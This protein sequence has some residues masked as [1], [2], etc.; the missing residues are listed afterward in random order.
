M[1]TRT[2]I[3]LV[4]AAACLQGCATQRKLSAIR[5]ESMSARLSL[6]PKSE[7][8]RSV[9][10]SGLNEKRDTIRIVD[11]DGKEM[12]LMNAIQDD[13]GD[14]VAME[15]LDAVV[16]TAT[17]RNVA[18]R[19]GKVDLQ[20]QI[21]VPEAMQDSRWQLRFYPDMYIMQDSVRLESIIITGNDYRKAQLRGYQ[22]YEKFLSSIITDT[23]EFINTW[24]LELFLERNLPQ[25]YALKSDTTFV[26]DDDFSSL[27]GVTEKQAVDHYTDHWRKRYNERRKSRIGL[28]YKRY[29]KAPLIT[30]GLRL[31]TLMRGDN[32]DFIYNYT[33]TIDTRPKLRKVEVVL[34]G[35][36]FEQGTRLYDIPPSD[37]LTFYISSLSSFVD[38]TERY[39]TRVIERRV[40]ANTACYIDFAAGKADIDEDLGY[41]R[42]E[43]GRIKQNLSDLLENTKFDLD[44]ITISAYASPEGSVKA[45]DALSLRRARSASDYFSRY[46]RFCQDSLALERGFAVDEFGNIIRNDDLPQIQFRSRS[47]GENWAMLDRLVRED[48]EL[49]DADKEEYASFEGIADKDARE[50]AMQKMKSYR[51]L[52]SSFYPK[53]RIVKF[54]F[55][56]HR[57]GMVKDTVHTTVLDSVY[58]AGVQAIRDRDYQTAITLLRPYNDYNAAIAFCS[59]DYDASAL[60]ILET[61]DR[62]PQVLYMLAILY[63]RRGDDQRAVQ[64]FL[65]ACHDEPSY[66]HRG[67]LDP[68][69][70]VL[71]KR[72]DLSARLDREPEFTY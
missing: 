29:V 16:C 63:S 15:V 68:E 18:E 3:I 53:L 60:N 31:D 24:Q 7:I 65:D 39:M 45:N 4:L 27:Y 50:K 40:E 52:R 9:D 32:G 54:D 14:M 43:M 1:K 46:V 22:Q 37:T 66:I 17:F 64:C 69:I 30:E 25:I 56:L 48:T 72:Y 55:F 67:N 8:A 71:I 36:I 62:T 35:E 42:E 61:L 58:M 20:F 28:M 34:R 5:S 59:M 2:F 57:K 26:S 12:Y 11:F 47:N 51:A 21:T 23:T 6:P 13:N 49:T 19:H 41:N 10:T 70:S 33:Q 38:G 44:S